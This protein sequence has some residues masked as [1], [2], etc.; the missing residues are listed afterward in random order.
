MEFWATLSLL[1]KIYFCI[2]LAASVFLVL[3]IIT[4]LFGIG[5]S[6]DV[7]VDLTGDGEVDVT[8]DGSDGFTLFSIRGIVSFFAIGGWT[9]YALSYVSTPL[10]VVGSLVAGFL[11]LVGMAFAI[12]G[13]MNLRSSGNIE[14][15]KAIGSNAVVYLTIPAKG[16]GTG[17]ITMTLE[18]R[19]VELNALCNNEQSIPTGA[20][21]KVVG[22][23]G[24]VLVVEP[25]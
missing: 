21:V 9:G 8:I 24:D 5:D 2:G 13:V 15:S 4:L 3:Q 25:I 1:Q 10:S 18:E 23:V 11:A 12:R 7:D 19:F 16:N 22:I 20:Q 17:K 14:I 6:G